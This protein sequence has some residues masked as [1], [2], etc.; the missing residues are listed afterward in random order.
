MGVQVCQQDMQEQVLFCHLS[1]QDDLMDQLG[2]QQ[3]L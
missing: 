2:Y 3:C 1:Q